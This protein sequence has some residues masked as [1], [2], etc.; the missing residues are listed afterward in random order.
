MNLL[1]SIIQSIL[2]FGLGL[3]SLFFN[4]ILAAVA[5]TIA[6]FKRRNP[7]LWGIATLFFPW[8][9]LLVFI[10][11]R[12]YPRLPNHLKNEEAFRD[13]NPVIASI[14]ALA[15]IVAKSDGA[16]TK[17]EVSFLRQFVSKQFGI[18]GEELDSYG[19]AFNYGKNHPNEYKDFTDIIISFYNRR[20]IMIS[21]AYLLVAIAMQD[22]AISPKEDNQIRKILLE[23]GLS[24]YEYSSIKA[25]FVKNESYYHSYD[26]ATGFGQTQDS[27]I[28]KYC[29]VLGVDERASMGDIKKAYR[30]LVKEYHPDKLAAE[31]M[32]KEYVEFANEKIRQINQAY[33]Y[34]QSVKEV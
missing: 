29:E 17:Q 20:D 16:I 27:L 4:I 6:L 2:G 13:K 18:V 11:P 23:L 30:K 1:L 10:M 3:V 12:R 14:M 8:V 28:K 34:L 31:S 19:A 7:W 22:E 25:S 21:I 9:I 32:P 5:A 15:A 33:E 26:S 24:E